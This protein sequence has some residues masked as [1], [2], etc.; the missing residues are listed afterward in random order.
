MTA[1][2]GHFQLPVLRERLRAKAGDI[3][4]RRA[5]MRVR[6]DHDMN[7]DLVPRPPLVPAAVLVPVIAHAGDLTV[8][9]TRRSDHLNDHAGQVSFPGGRLEP[10]DPDAVAAA[11]RESE[12]EIGLPP[13]AVEVI[14]RLDTY[15]TR[16]GYEVTP[17][18]GI[19]TPPVAFRPDPFEVAEVFEVPL[20]FILDAANHRRQSRIDANGIERHFWV[21]PYE[22]HYIWGATAGMLVNLYEVVRGP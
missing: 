14:G 15:Q 1:I 4:I 5:G 18:V 16:T 8:V 9:L 6:G 2:G 13:S 22:R 21:L 12:E 3:G 7:P 17:V 19:V 20:G 10:E 11:L